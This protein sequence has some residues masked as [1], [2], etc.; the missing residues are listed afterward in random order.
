MLGLSLGCVRI[1][2]V[3]QS[4]PTPK[5]CLTR[6]NHR[7]GNAPGDNNAWCCWVNASFMPLR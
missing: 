6:N 1:V 5:N 3:L 2:L 4:T 7:L